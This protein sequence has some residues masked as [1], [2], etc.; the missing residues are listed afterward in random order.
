MKNID[1]KDYRVRLYL[2]LLFVIFSAGIIFAGILYYKN[3]EKHYRTEIENQI[4]AIA[5]LKVGELVQWRRERLGDGNLFYKNEDFTELV[6]RYFNDPDDVDAVRKISVWIEKVQLY[7]NYNGIFILDT[8]FTKRIMIPEKTERGKA[9]VS[10]KIYDSLKKGK[11]I[12]E[13]FYEDDLNKKIFLEVLVPVLDEKNGNRII[14]IVELRIDPESYLYPLLNKWPTP[15][16]T[17]ETLIIRRE[18]NEVVYLNDI[19][20]QAGSALKFR[21]PLERRD[22]LA[23][24][25]VLG[26]TGVVEGVDY[27]GEEVI[28]YICPVP[29]SP[30]YMVA[31]MDKSEVYAPLKER[32][33]TML[34]LVVMFIFGSG[35]GIGFIWRHQSIRFYKEKSETQDLLIASETRYRRLF[36]TAK[37]GIIILDA[38]TGMIVDINPFLLDMLGYSYEAFLKK[39]IWEIG[40]FKNVIANKD[41]FLELQQ[42]E[43]IRYEDL[44]L[45]TADGKEV[46]VEFVSNVY[47]VN[48]SKVIQCN[49]RDITERKRADMEIRKFY[50]ELEQRVIERTAQLQN[51][52]SEL[53]AYSYSVSHDLRA[54]LRGIDGFSLALYEDYFDKLDDTA[55]NYIERIRAG[56]KKMDELIDSLLKL[57]RVSRFEMKVE[58]VNLSA[59]VKGIS[60]ALTESGGTRKADFIIQENIT[61]MCDANLM[62][63][64]FENLLSNAWKFTSKTDKTV[65]EFGVIKENLKL[66]YYIRDNGVGFDMMYYDKLF[67]AFQRLHPETEYPGTGIGLT[68]VQRIIGR[69]NGEIRAESK[70]NEGTTFY[71]TL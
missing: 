59:M 2:I 8:L 49:I 44:P 57:S 1:K 7:Y 14:G 21:I 3:Y 47:M 33:W 68:T 31:R 29:D 24:K 34:V 32:R 6:R 17:S 23:V 26:E 65:I 36:E 43:Y 10:P 15:S 41:N 27:R 67:G 46:H 16:K 64:V 45:E 5:D 56:T 35:A 28:G 71:F 11:I 62:N 30:W 37:D 25:A 18:G 39:Y 63:I 58:S 50:A 19:K 13:D 54:P 20:F 52:N 4:T 60:N 55:K 70:L 38:E 22:I 66:V 12:Y 40:F 51:A 61:A 69:H 53:E 42:K 9:L 48:N